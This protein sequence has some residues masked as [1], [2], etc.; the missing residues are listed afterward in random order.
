MEISLK[1]DIL[2]LV[3]PRGALAPLALGQNFSKGIKSGIFEK[4]GLQYE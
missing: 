4:K 1:T 3:T 2:M